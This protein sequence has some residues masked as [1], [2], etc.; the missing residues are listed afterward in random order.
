MRGR[1]FFSARRRS[2]MRESKSIAVGLVLTAVVAAQGPI[3]INEIHCV[4]TGAAPPLQGDYIELWNTSAQP[5]FLAGWTLGTWNGNAGTLTQRLLAAP[6]VIEGHCYIIL[7]EGGVAGAAITDPNLPFGTRGFR[8][9]GTLPWPSNGSAGVFLK[10]PLGV[11]SDYVYL[12]RGLASSI[13]TAAPYLVANAGAGAAWTVGSVA[14][15]GVGNGHLKRMTNADVHSVADWTQDASANVGTP[16]NPNTSGGATQTALGFCSGLDNVDFCLNGQ[17]NTPGATLKISGVDGPTY[18]SLVDLYADTDTLTI[19]V[20]TNA[21]VMLGASALLAFSPSC[22]VGHIVDEIGQRFDLGHSTASF[23]DVSYE[24]SLGIGNPCL[25]LPVLPFGILGDDGRAAA[26][27]VLNGAVFPRRYY[28]GVLLDPTGGPALLTAAIGIASLPGRRYRATGALPLTVPD[29]IG[30]GPGA[31]V[32]HD[33]V[34]AA[35]AVP[36]GATVADLD[37]HVTLAHTWA[38]DV[39]LTLTKVGTNLVVP[40][41]TSGTPDVNADLI[42]LYRFTDEAVQ[43]FD[44]ALTAAAGGAVA[45]GLYRPDGL[46]S[47][48]DG[49]SL[50]GTWRLTLFDNHAIDSGQLVGWALVLNGIQ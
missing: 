2:I 35:T 46:F 21:P 40:I 29:G 12:H 19:V 17:P 43:P 14:T 28:Q 34:I 1:V 13:P 30:S 45:E 32:T 8:L 10:S 3:L 18:P 48:F 50:D 47:V 37:L 26:E 5:I 44:A 42:G 16:A 25:G 24:S 49:Q 27:M 41:L 20:T 31:S 39:N 38:G 6:M 33:L 7:Q 11:N 36:A 15:S 9:G 22:N 23:C 4:G